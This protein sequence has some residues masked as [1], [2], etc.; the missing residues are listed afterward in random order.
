MRYATITVFRNGGYID[1]GVESPDVIGFAQMEAAP[2]ILP[3]A[4][5][6]HKYYGPCGRCHV[7]APKNSSVNSAQLNKDLG[8][9]LAQSPP[10]IHINSPLTH[11]YRGVCQ[12]CHEIVV[13]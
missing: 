10:P 6:P 9:T 13:N 12:N 1:I 4:T 8:D 2:M 5:S 3:G 7:I 11:R